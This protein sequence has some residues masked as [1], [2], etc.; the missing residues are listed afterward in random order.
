VGYGLDLQPR[1]ALAESWETSADGKVWTFHLR[2]GVT[3]QDGSR[4]TARDVAFTYTYIIDNQMEAFSSLTTYIDEWWPWTTQPWSS[5]CSKPKA[6]MLRTW[7]PILPEHV[8]SKVKPGAAPNSSSNKPPFIGTGPFQVVEVK[9]G[10]YVKMVASPMFW[11][12][13]PAVDEILFVTYQNPDTMTQDL[14]NGT[15]DA[16]WGIPRHS[17]TSS[18]T[19]PASRGSPTTSSTGTTSP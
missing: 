18:R 10:Q 6:N 2:T 15:L 17:S 13:K 9:K 3:W 11:G 8:W 14:L 16:A 5:R 12:Q 19:S 1:P 7:I 4:F